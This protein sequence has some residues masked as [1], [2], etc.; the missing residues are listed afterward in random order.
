M[1]AAL[2]AVLGRLRNSRRTSWVSAAPSRSSPTRLTIVSRKPSRQ[3][4]RASSR[5]RGASSA[6]SAS[7]ASRKRIQSPVAASRPTLRAAAKSSFHACSRTLAPCSR[8]ISAV[9]SVE[10]VSTTTISSTTSCGGGAARGRGWPPRRGRSCT[11]RSRPRPAGFAR[12]GDCDGAALE[13][14]DLRGRS[15]PAGCSVW[16]ACGAGCA[17]RVEVALRGSG[18]AGSS[19][20]AARSSGLGAA[21]SAPSWKS[22]TPARLSRTG[23]AGVGGERLERDVRRWRAGRR[24]CRRSG[25]ARVLEAELDERA[26][27]DVAAVRVG[28]GRR[29]RRRARGSRRGRR[30][31][32]AVR[33]RSSRATSGAAVG[34]ADG[35]GGGVGQTEGHGPV[36]GRR[37]RALERTHV[38]RRASAAQAPRAAPIRCAPASPM[39]VLT[40][41]PI[42]VAAPSPAVVWQ[43]YRRTGDRAPARPARLH[44]RAA[45]PARRRARTPRRRQL[46][47]VARSLDRRRRRT[48]PERDGPLERF[49]LGRASARPLEP[50]ASAR[51]ARP[52]P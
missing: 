36:V 27:R 40:L 39:A 17:T 46:G 34:A 32:S 30:R 49:A 2:E 42:P 44:P 22:A 18:T 11:A 10:P 9:R 3:V 35:G 43:Q 23:S 38:R 4:R 37:P 20:A 16:R 8:A 21:L 33:A 45:R 41:A 26:A 14:G 50:L 13:R 28:R 12:R 48:S 51:R 7:S 19:A 24:A 6:T 29:S 52:A 5:S 15:R 25:A 1:D 31:P 47:P